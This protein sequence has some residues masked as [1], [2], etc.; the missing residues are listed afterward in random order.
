MNPQ[1]R[2]SLSGLLAVCLLTLSAMAQAGP[3]QDRY[4]V[5]LNADAGMPEAVAADV[6]RRTSGR[7]GYVYGTAL[8][9]F[10]I[11]MPRAALAGLARDP[12]VA[13]VEED[14]PVR[15]FGQEV[16]TGVRRM[17]ADQAAL[18][19][20]GLDDY[21]VDADVAVL[22]TGID[23]QHPDLNVVGGANCLNSTGGGPP[24]KR[25]YFCDDTRDGDDDHYHG[26]HVAGTIGA[27]DNGIGVVGVAPG[28][29]LWAVK[30]LDAQGS[31]SLAGI[32]AGIDWVAARGG[33]EVINMS[34]GGSGS[35]TAMDN[36]IRNAVDGGVTVVV[37]A[38][39]EDDDAA[40]HTPANS[41]DA[42]TVSALA[43]FDGA[44]GGYGAPTCRPDQDDTLADFSNWGATVDIAAPGVCIRSTYPL[45]RGGYGTISGT[46]MASPHVAGAAALLASQG[47]T[48]QA[49]R[50]TLLGKG[51]FNW[52]DDSGDGVLE[53]L[54]DI[55]DPVFAPVFVTAGGGGSDT[56]A[57]PTAA[58][59]S[60]CA[61]L[62]CDF[63]GRGSSDSDGS[64][65]THAW[66]FGDGATASGPTAS[67]TYATDGTYTVSL[68][69]TDD[70]GASGT[71]QHD[72]TVASGGGGE[73]LTSSQ[74]NGSTWTAMVE[75]ADGSGLTGTW[76]Y[77]GGT[78]G[79][80]GSACTLG[81]IR[82]K[83]SSVEFT[84]GTGTTVTVF[85]P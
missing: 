40:N 78:E 16:P 72:V 27:L 80:S 18:A 52:T 38:G 26:T 54:L 25:S 66:D 49:I 2:H 84:S 1:S 42:I 31:G 24:W 3:P 15:A 74:N 79:C 44:A 75:T 45:E 5:V 20:D 65:V 58:F 83:V 82:K 57:P 32:I 53:P 69:V 50:D 35:S 21:R 43:D 41:P 51:N 17:F 11:T 23:R 47:D 4:I 67:H 10:S 59:T 30:V 61:G 14:I 46:S 34:L 63:D 64:I 7:V 60:A 9:G 71:V 81:G 29:R 22:D 8:R 12:R 62:G 36:A 28:A 73:L 39:N 70:G 37:A 76:S 77:S 85:K 68:T 13:Y 56:N 19:I 48:P 33:I 6:A 55:G